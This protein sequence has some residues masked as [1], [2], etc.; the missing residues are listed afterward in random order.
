MRLE[1]HAWRLESRIDALTNGLKPFEGIALSAADTFVV[2]RIIIQLQIEWE[3]FVRAL[4]LDS[5]TG[6]HST[7][8]GPVASNL[9]LKIRSREHASHVLIAQYKKRPNEP[10][11]YLPQDAI[12]AAG[13]LSLT[14]ENKIAAELGVT[15]WGLSDLRHLRN[16]I[17][18]RSG[19]SAINLRTATAVAKSDQVMPTA[20]CYEYAA[21]GMRRYESWAAFMKGVAKRLVD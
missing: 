6:R 2:E 5:A 8:S 21:G 15:P 4:I 13:K 14:N 1:R 9:P 19:R 20:L 10:D 18:H 11:W 7:R 16:F 17:S 12:A 3:H